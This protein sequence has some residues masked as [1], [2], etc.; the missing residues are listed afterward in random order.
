MLRISVFISVYILVIFKIYAVSQPLVKCISVNNDGSI[1]LTWQ[2]PS[3]ITNFQQYNIYRSNSISGNFTL[4]DS[5]SNIN[6]TTYTDF[7]VN[8][9]SQS[10]YYFLK[11]KSINGQLSTSS[12][13]IR[14]IFLTLTNIGGN[15][16]SLSWNP[17]HFPPISGSSL[18]YKIYSKK[19]SQ[20]TWILRD[21]TQNLQYTDTVKVC[22]DTVSYKVE[23]NNSYGCYSVSSSDKK[24]FEDVISPS[25]VNIDSVSVD[26]SNDITVIGWIPSTTN[27]T[28]GY[29]ICQGSPCVTIDTIWG[30]NSSFYIDSINN[31][32]NISTSYRLTAFDSCFNKSP[33][34]VPHNNILLNSQLNVCEGKITMSWNKY[35]NMNPAL[36]GYRILLSINGGNYTTIAD[37][38]AST[39]NYTI[40]N[41]IDSNYYCFYVQAYSQNNKITSSSCK[42]CYFF[43][44]PPNPS[45]L[46]LSSASVISDNQNIIKIYTDPTIKV[47]GFQVQRADLLTGPF[48]NLATIPYASLTNYSYTDNSVD[49]SKKVYYYR[50]Q[51][52]DSCGNLGKISNTARTILLNGNALDSYTNSLNW[53]TYGDWVGG[54]DIYE[55]YRSI[56]GVYSSVPIATIPNNP[57]LSSYQYN[58]DIKSLTNTS[59]KFG[60]YIKAIE[61]PN[62]TYYFTEESFSN[63]IEIN[64]NPEIFVPN[65]FVPNGLNTEFKPVAAFVNPEGYLLQIYNRYGQL[66]FETKQPDVGWDGKYQGEYVKQG[67]YFYLIRYKKPEQET[68]QLYGSV[69]VIF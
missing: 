23:N 48:S 38:N 55:I 10:Y 3:D 4:I 65:A 50:I 33:L 39:Y 28:W 9:N 40:S 15:I 27:D 45:V 49:A 18:Y 58:D 29:I 8:G 11:S 53:T 26:I 43:T 22:S 51:C 54:V 37:L 36:Q 35:N 30:K 59:G 32:C 52:S 6:L 41:L 16:A 19:V 68:K 34:S 63:K 60:Y 1:T 14:S 47:N 42:K 25:T 67:V 17:T 12:D 7:N 46:Y 56:N 20:T 31:P 64:Q 57:S 2:K 62:A 13:T 44:K 24:L 69:T 21:S 66:I 61:K 5:I